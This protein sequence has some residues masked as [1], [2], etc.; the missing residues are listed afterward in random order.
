[1]RWSRLRVVMDVLAIGAMVYLGQALQAT[2]KSPDETGTIVAAIGH[3]DRICPRM[4]PYSQFCENWMEA[5]A[6]LLHGLVDVC[7]GQD[8]VQQCRTRMTLEHQESRK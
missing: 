3:L 6:T 1:M 8:D 4:R 2:A 5:R 7:L